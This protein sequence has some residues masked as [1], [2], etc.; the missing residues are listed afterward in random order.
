MEVKCQ[1]G[2]HESANLCDWGQAH[3]NSHMTRE[4]HEGVSALSLAGLDVL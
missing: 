2:G 3:D 4:G 1:V